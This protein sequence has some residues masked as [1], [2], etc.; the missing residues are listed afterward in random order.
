MSKLHLSAN[1]QTIVDNSESTLEDTL[2]E[3]VDTPS[4]T[5]Y[6]PAMDFYASSSNPNVPPLTTPD[7]VLIKNTYKQLLSAFLKAMGV[8]KVFANSS[9]VTGVSGTI[10]LRKLTDPSGSN[11]SLTFQDG[12][13]TSYTPP[14]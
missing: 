5:G 10:P 12:V 11:G 7:K 4:N 6:L 8:T 14:T 3:G 13:L 2:A 9:F 1:Q